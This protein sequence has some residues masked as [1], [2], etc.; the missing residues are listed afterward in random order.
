MSL[1][2]FIINDKGSF[3]YIAKIYVLLPATEGFSNVFS[4][5]KVP[6]D[7]KI[8]VTHYT[9]EAHILSGQP[10]ST[11]HKFRLMPASENSEKIAGFGKY[12]RDRKKAAV[13][14]I[15][16]TADCYILPPAAERNLL[17]QGLSCLSSICLADPLA[18]PTS[19]SGSKKISNDPSP[20]GF[21]SNL[22]S[23]VNQSES[24]M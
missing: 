20:K 13:F 16:D 3:D 23:K 9:R 1:E 7:R 2:L 11:L 10:N 24:N 19:S 17:T 4:E 6:S 14:K 8:T 18:A 12:L 5:E 21:L 15:G 22:L